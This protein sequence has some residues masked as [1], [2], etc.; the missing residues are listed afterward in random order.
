VDA[1]RT[2]TLAAQSVW[3]QRRR[4]W[5]AA[6][7]IAVGVAAMVAMVAVGQGAERSVVEKIQAMGSDLVVV[8]AGQVKLVAGR[9]RQVGNVTTLKLEDLRA[10]QE[11]CPSVARAVAVQSRKLP[12]KWGEFAA[13]TTV[14]GTGVDFLAVRNFALAQGRSFDDDEERAGLRVAVLG[15]TVARNLFGERNPVGETLRIDNVPFEVVGLLSAKGL[16]GNGADQDDQI[17]VPLRTALRRLFNLD[18]VNN[19]YVQARPGLAAAAVAELTDAIRER[20]HLKEGRPE[21][22]TVQNQADVLAAEEAAAKSFTLLLG[23]VAAVALLIGGV[24]VLAVML[25]S[26]KERTREIGLRRAI[27]ASRRDVLLQFVGEALAI[28]V[29]GGLFG[30]ALGAGSASGFALLGS[31]PVLLSKSSAALAVA[32]STLVAVGFG[33]IPA[34][35]AAAMDPANSLRSA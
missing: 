26:V 32:V 12:L 6:V 4:T 22:F 31:W 18:H 35:R 11:S 24:G 17:L 9:P 33:A 19:L 23:A 20:H 5:P 13:S 7:G 15:A 2:A 28:G 34:R 3:R 10:V 1:R 30:L 27:G 16:D 25:I 21:D 14:V 8:S 29:A